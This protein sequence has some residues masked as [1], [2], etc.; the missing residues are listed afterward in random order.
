MLRLS[1]ILSASLIGNALAEPVITQFAQGKPCA[2]SLEY[3]DSMTSQVQNLIPLLQQYRFHATFFINPGRP[4]YQAAR[5]VWEKQVPRAGHELANHTMHHADT[6]GADQASTEIGSVAKIIERIVGHPI[7]TPFG[8]PG[9]V[10]WEVSESDLGRILKENNL[11]LPGRQ[12]FYEDGQGDITRFPRMALE[13]KSWRRLGF[14]G[15]GG[16]WLSTSVDN[17]SI[18][19]KFLD[20]NKERM[21]I[22]PTGTVWKYARE[23]EALVKID[24]KPDGTIVPVFNRAD[25][26]PFHLYTVPLTMQVQT[27]PMWRKVTVTVDGKKIPVVLKGHT[28]QFEFLPQTKSIVVRKG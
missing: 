28:A 12:D 27:P 22:A 11:F 4:Q 3:D 2:F 18:L 25:L 6:I 24:V 17:M 20:S 8:T 1:I 15:V 5:D 21:W 16:E 10:K 13:T 19:F 7:L 26:V 14:H 23:R 9:G